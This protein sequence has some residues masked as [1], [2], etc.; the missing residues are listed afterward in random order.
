MLSNRVDVIICVYDLTKFSASVIIDVIRSHP[1]ILIGSV[2]HEN[3][4]Y[5]PPETLLAELRERKIGDRPTADAE[6]V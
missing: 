3:P 2:L 6:F 1:A 5:I 4:F